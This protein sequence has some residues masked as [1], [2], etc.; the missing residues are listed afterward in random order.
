MKFNLLAR[1]MKRSNLKQHM[2]TI[3]VNMSEK[4]SGVIDIS[5]KIN[6]RDI[7]DI[8]NDRQNQKG[9]FFG[10]EIF[11]FIVKID[12]RHKPNGTTLWSHECQVLLHINI[13]FR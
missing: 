9:M 8:Q 13:I 1:A 12:L 10:L 6:R 7:V 5:C 3:V 2:Q 4:A 11:L